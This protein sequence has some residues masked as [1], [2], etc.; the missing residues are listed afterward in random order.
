MLIGEWKSGVDLRERSVNTISLP[1]KVRCWFLDNMGVDLFS[2]T[3]EL[4][5][6]IRGALMTS[7]LSAKE[8]KDYLHGSLETREALRSAMIS[9]AKELRSKLSCVPM[10]P[11]IA[12]VDWS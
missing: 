7:T 3:G 4:P 5:R 12:K 2:C 1:Y 6:M 8:Q 11:A 10:S 9:N